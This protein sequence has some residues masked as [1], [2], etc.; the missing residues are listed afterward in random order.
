MNDKQ[1]EPKE[2]QEIEPAFWQDD[3]QDEGEEK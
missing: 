1:D 3:W 2:S